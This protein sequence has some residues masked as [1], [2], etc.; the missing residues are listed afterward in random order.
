MGKQYSSVAEYIKDT[1]KNKKVSNRL[2]RKFTGN[3]VSKLLVLIRC[4]NRLSQNQLAKKI[5]CSQSRISKIENA[6]N[7][8]LSINDLFLYAKGLNLKLEIG[9]RQSNVKIVDLIKYHAVKINSYLSTLRKLAQDDES[10][11]EAIEAFHIEAFFNLSKM[12]LKGIKMPEDK[13]TGKQILI[14]PPLGIKE[15]HQDCMPV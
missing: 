9:F 13:V 1:T 15:K 7:R 5:G 3:S 11:K 4:N 14:S 10:L 8:E 12:T 2:L 6:E